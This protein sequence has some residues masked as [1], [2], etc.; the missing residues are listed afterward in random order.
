[1]S[2][3]TQ[4]IA[5]RLAA[6]GCDVHVWCRGDEA[7]ATDAASG[8][9]IHRVVGAFD[10]SGLRRLSYSLDSFPGRRILFVQ[11]V[12]HAFGLRAMNVPFCFWLRGRRRAGDEVRVLFHEV[13]FPFV[14]RPLKWNVLA[15][16]Q[17]AMA[18]IAVRSAAKVYVSAA[19][20]I[21]Y[22]GRL[23]LGDKPAVVLPVPS[24]FPVAIPPEQIQ[25]ARR[26]LGDADSPI[27]GHF[28]TYGAAITVLLTPLL[29]RLLT[30]F[31]SLHVALIGRGSTAYRREF[32]VTDPAYE[33]RLTAFDDLTRDKVSAQIQ[34]C[35]FMLQPFPDGASSRR[36][37]LM[38][39]LAAAAPVITTYGDLSEP[40]W[41]TQQVC[42]AVAVGDDAAVVEIAKRWIADP[43]LRKS[44]GVQAADY[45]QV[46]F[47]LDR[48]I[49]VLLDRTP[50]A[51]LQ[52]QSS[53]VVD[54]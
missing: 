47:S 19:A 20:W 35:D 29:R 41:Q 53:A 21:P 7:T 10:R 42:A 5:S 32:I 44:V 6:E 48:T 23:G 26:R 49:G 25:A 8:L 9:T 16:V 40:V 15:I 43:R 51:P 1:V 17:R 36:T 45:Y 12:P 4:L 38:A 18:A 39:C 46:H 13:A 2:D 37:S 27:A 31:P 34:A 24:N 28:G 33:H 14:R 22:L 11:Y 54:R 3:Y 52:I 50:A 30:E